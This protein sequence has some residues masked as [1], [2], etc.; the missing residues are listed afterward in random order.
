MP[1]IWSARHAISHP[2]PMPRS[3]PSTLAEHRVEPAFRGERAD[4]RA[5]AHPHRPQ[6]AELGAPFVGQHHEDVDE[7]EHAGGDREHPDGEVELRQRVTRLVGAVEQVLLDGLRP[8]RE[9]GRARGRSRRPRPRCAPR[10]P[11]RR[12]RSRRATIACGG[13]V[14]DPVG[15]GGRAPAIVP[16]ATN[17]LYDCWRASIVQKPATP[18]RGRMRSTV[19]ATCPPPAKTR[20]R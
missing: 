4:Q 19:S 3:A 6:H 18:R 1:R 10:R 12:P 5:P 13:S 11:R 20:M 2:K 7:E 16:G 17:T 9:P 14:V 8:S 15:A